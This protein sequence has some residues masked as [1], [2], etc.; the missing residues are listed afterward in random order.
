VINSVG[1]FKKFAKSLD[2]G[3]SVLLRV[4]LPTKETTY[5]PIKAPL[6]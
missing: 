2:S 4:K 3:E 5:I 1:D 6:E